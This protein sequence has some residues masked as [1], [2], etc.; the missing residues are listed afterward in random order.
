MQLRFGRSFPVA[1][2]LIFSL[3]LSGCG[4]SS[5]GGGVADASLPPDSNWS[6][7]P[8]SSSNPTPAPIHPD[9][10]Y[11]PRGL[12]SKAF[13][14]GTRTIAPMDMEAQDLTLTLD[15][16]AQTT[17]GESTISFHQNSNSRPAFLLDATVRSIRLDG[18]DVP[19]SRVSDPVGK[20]TL[21]M[22]DRALSSGATHVAEVRYQLPSARVSYQGGGVGFLTDMADLLARFFDKWGPANFEDDQFALTLRFVV[23]N[24]TSNHQVFANGAVSHPAANEWVVRYPSNYN[25][26]SFFAHLTNRSLTVN[27]FSYQGLERSIPI[28]VYSANAANVATV[29]AQIPKLF[30]ELERDYGPYLHPGFV[31]YLND[32]NG[33]IEFAGATITQPRSVSHEL[34]HSWFARGVMPAEGRAGWIDEAAA[35]WRDH[36]YARLTSLLS[37]TPTSLG[38]GSIYDRAT[39]SNSYGDGRALL[40]ELDQLFASRG[41]MKALFRGLFAK[42]KGRLITTAEFRS[43]LEETTGVDLGTYFDRYVYGGKTMPFAVSPAMATAS[44]DDGSGDSFHPPSLTEEELQA[45]R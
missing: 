6:P 36:G 40:G 4:S 25:S 15:A 34:F 2:S 12:S 29:S 37:R 5:S 24:A 26:S 3:G 30:Q 38:N 41:G 23:K 1:L 35:S 28:T 13:T 31:V 33:G 8:G 21:V 16:K 10:S 27:R 42:Y 9:P 17:V 18:A 44:G 22:I 39:P 11:R 7:D 20:N 14:I 43:Y 19:F 32:Y 45:L